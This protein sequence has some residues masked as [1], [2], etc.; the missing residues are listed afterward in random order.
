MT[1]FQF[2]NRSMKIINKNKSFTHLPDI[3]IIS[4]NKIIEVKVRGHI[5]KMRKKTYQNNRDV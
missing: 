3:Y 2:V 5:K 1:I 4:E